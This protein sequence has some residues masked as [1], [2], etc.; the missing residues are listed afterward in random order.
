MGYLKI[1]AD[2][3]SRDSATDFVPVSWSEQALVPKMT[4]IKTGTDDVSGEA[5][6]I[7]SARIL[8]AA[9]TLAGL[10]QKELAERTGMTRLTILRIESGEREALDARRKRAIAQLVRVLE[11]HGIEFLSATKQSGEGV[12]FKKPSE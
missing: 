7:P 8:R 4:D 9:R 1:R 10:D 2:D 11:D 12:R 6:N 5:S 3:P